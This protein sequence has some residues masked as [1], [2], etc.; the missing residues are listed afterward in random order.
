MKNTTIKTN[1]TF[2]KEHIPD[3][4]QINHFPNLWEDNWIKLRKNGC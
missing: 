2:F 1:V 4:I 3:N